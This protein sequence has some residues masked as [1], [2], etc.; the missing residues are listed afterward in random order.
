MSVY[1]IVSLLG[2]FLSALLFREQ[3]I[4]SGVSLFPIIIALISVI[5]SIIF[6]SNINCDSNDN[7]A[8][9]LREI[10]YESYRVSIKWHY[11]CKSIIVPILMVFV[12][13]FNNVLKIIMPVSIY[14]ISYLPI[15]LLVKLGH[16]K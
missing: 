13:F 2:L 12:I 6:K 5:Q 9:S 14:F 7:T 11:L 15:R 1:Y 10:D 3:I 16:K 8:F 4:I